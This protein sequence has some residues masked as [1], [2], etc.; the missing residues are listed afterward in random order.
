[1]AKAKTVAE[2]IEIEKEVAALRS[3]IEVMEGR[4]R[5]M[6]NQIEFS[7]VWVEFYV[8][9]IEESSSYGW[10]FSRGF[11]DGWNNFLGFFVG[12][13]YIWPFVIIA[14]VGFVFLRRRWRKRKA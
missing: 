9:Q 1:M 2:I 3:D 11:V 7:T 14:I 8:K 5:L 4:M 12:L 10:R 13:T 6:K